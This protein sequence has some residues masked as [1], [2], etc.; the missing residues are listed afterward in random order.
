MGALKNFYENEITEGERQRMED[1]DLDRQYDEFL[2]E[3][4]NAQ[5]EKQAFVDLAYLT[6]T[7]PA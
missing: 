6:G 5:A 1:A 3:N 2:T 7:L 4:V